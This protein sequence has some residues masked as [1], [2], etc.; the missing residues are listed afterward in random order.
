MVAD[1]RQLGHVRAAVACNARSLHPE[2][3]DYR[4][5]FVQRLTDDLNAA[6]PYDVH[7][8]AQDLATV[9]LSSGNA[10][11]SNTDKCRAFPPG[12]FAR[13]ICPANST[14]ACAASAFAWSWA[15]SRSS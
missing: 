9:A 15:V 4:V 10:V 1:V 11:F 8:R 3:L 2:T 12:V 14:L 5:D 13:Q 6:D 7:G